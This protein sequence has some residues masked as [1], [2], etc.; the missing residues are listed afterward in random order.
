VPTTTGSLEVFLQ[1]ERQHGMWADL[2]EEAVAFRAQLLDGACELNALPQVAIPVVRVELCAVDGCTGH[3]RIHRDGA[4]PGRER[5]QLRE[6][7]IAN[8]FDV[9]AVRAVVD[10]DFAREDLRRAER[11]E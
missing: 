9:R 1:R 11:L 7:L 3:R 4:G 10:A 5:L 6:Q 8:G 2:D